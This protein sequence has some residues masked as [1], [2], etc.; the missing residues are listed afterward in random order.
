[1]FVTVFYVLIT[2]IGT[3]LYP[4]LLTHSEIK[5]RWLVSKSRA[6]GKL[7]RHPLFIYS[8]TLNL[9]PFYLR[10][11]QTAVDRSPG[12]F[13]AKFCPG[14]ILCNL[15]WL[16][17]GRRP[18]APSRGS[19]ELVTCSA[20]YCLCYSSGCVF[21][22]VWAYPWVD[23]LVCLW[24]IAC[25]TSRTAWVCCLLVI[26]VLLLVCCSWCVVIGVLLL[27][28]CYWCVVIGVLLL[29][30]CSWCVV[31]GVLLLVCCYCCI[32]Y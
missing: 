20:E 1:M 18:A 6:Q 12:I 27:V 22:P 14:C 10:C 23:F 21:G 26:G 16:W 19:R 31:I 25:V 24:S 2:N 13:G 30:C 29:V 4:S 3:V 8:P 5:P 9:E 28:C 17:G 32:R 11:C 15:G 7:R